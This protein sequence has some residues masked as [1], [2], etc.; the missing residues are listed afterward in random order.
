[1]RESGENVDILTIEFKGARE[2]KNRNVEKKS[3]LFGR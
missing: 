1:V 3:Q 2:M